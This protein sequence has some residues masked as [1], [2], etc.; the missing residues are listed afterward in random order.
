MSADVHLHRGLS[1]FFRLC[2][3]RAP[4]ACA[5][6]VRAALACCLLD[7]AS[8]VVLGLGACARYTTHVHVHTRPFQG[9]HCTT[10]AT[11]CCKLNDG[12]CTCGPVHNGRPIS[13]T[14]TVMP[15]S[16]QLAPV[17]PACTGVH[18]TTALTFDHDVMGLRILLHRR[19]ARHEH[20]SCGT[21]ICG[22]S[23]AL[24]V[25][26]P[27]CHPRRQAALHST[28][29]PM[30]Q[31]SSCALL[32]DTAIACCACN[33]GCPC[34]P[35]ADR[36]HSA[37]L[38]GP[39]S[40]TAAQVKGWTRRQLKPL[41]ALHR[42]ASRHY[43]SGCTVPHGTRGRSSSSGR[44]SG[45]LWSCCG[46]GGQDSMRPRA[47]AAVQELCT[48]LVS[49]QIIKGARGVKVI[50]S[51]GGCVARSRAQQPVFVTRVQHLDLSRPVRLCATGE[52]GGRRRGLR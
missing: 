42:R 39:A 44:G 14:A 6:S 46:C 16:C 49:T 21:T 38:R 41:T 1:A 10:S 27:A 43:S 2:S 22:M 47:L 48:E 34:I 32:L 31:L 26:C 20:D 4:A 24:L 23:Q 51:K 37:V 52:E 29:G 33:S 5:I 17:L 30:P 35:H 28:H 50:A 19:P 18:C 40:V 3:M 11:H 36:P 13:R 8:H 9:P 45:W 7:S 12:W 25:N 15:G